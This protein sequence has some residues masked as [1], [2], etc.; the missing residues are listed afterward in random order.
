MLRRWRRIVTSVVV[1]DSLPTSAELR[2]YSVVQSFITVACLFYIHKRQHIVLI[3]K[4]T[5][6][7]RICL[8]VAYLTSLTT[9]DVDELLYRRFTLKCV[10]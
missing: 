3:A 5:L 10:A 6:W 9:L 2:L 7:G 1:R 8:S 4:N